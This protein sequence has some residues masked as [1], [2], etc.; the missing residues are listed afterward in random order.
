MTLNSDGT[1]S[2]IHDGSEN[3][4]DSFTYTVF[5]GV[6]TSNEATV[7]ITVSGVNDNIPVAVD[8]AITVAEGGTA[9]TL[10]GGSGTVLNNDTDADAPGD[11]L[12]V[13]LVDD[14]ANGTL[15]L[16]SDGTFTYI[17]DGS[18]NLSD[19]FTY[20]VFDGVNTSNEATVTITVSAVNDS[21]PIA[22]DDAITVA[23]GGTATTLVGGSGTVLNNDTDADQPGDTLTVSLVD[24]VANGTLTLNSDGTFSY[25]HDGSENLSDSFTYTVFDGVNTSN[26]ATVTITVSGI[27]DNSPVANPD[28]IVLD[29]G[30]TAT[31]L[32]GGANSVLAN[33]TDADQ[34]GDTLT[35]NDEDSGTAGIQ[36]LVGPSF[37]NL[38][39]NSDGTFSYTHDGSENFSDGFIYGATDG[40]TT[41]YASVTITINP[42]NDLVPNAADDSITV[43]EG[44]STSILDGGAT[45]VL[46]NDTDGDTP[47]NSLTVN[48]ESGAPGIQIVS[49]PANGVLVINP[50]GTFTYTHD[51]SETTSDS[52]VYRTFD[53]NNVSGDATVNITVNAT[54]DPPQLIT[55]NISLGESGEI[56]VDTNYLDGSDADNT[57]DQ[58]V[59]TLTQDVQ[60]GDLVLFGDVIEVGATWSQQ[61]VNDGNL[62]YRHNGSSILTDTFLVQL[63]DGN[64]S[65]NDNVNISRIVAPE[66]PDAPVSEEPVYR[67][68]I[69][70]NPTKVIAK[71]PLMAQYAT[72]LGTGLG[73][74][75]GFMN[76]QGINQLTSF[77]TNLGYRQLVNMG[78]TVSSFRMVD[79][80]PALSHTSQD[81]GFTS[82]ANPI[83]EVYSP[84]GIDSRNIDAQTFIQELSGTDRVQRYEGDVELSDEARIL[85]SDLISWM[86]RFQ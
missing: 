52:F 49:G 8:D 44:Q 2:Y 73:R 46:A 58:L 37:G 78:D 1:F 25:I 28:S 62:I 7:T 48:D 12:T 54:D 47:A 32:V 81:L 51:G 56:T 86:N 27:N 16:N 11:T 79:S 36:V 72:G 61:M 33:D 21:I 57:P 64:S 75:F 53:G 10:V 69:I 80:Q 66:T 35:V 19:S 60:N 17:H 38:T 31:T 3:L 4:S 40:N 41:T 6:N 68:P 42:V 83:Q 18:E 9:T 70:L 82:D 84:Y 30:G 71:S 15:T 50:D 24:D 65:V 23:E 20:T 22:V 34:P 43:D 59:Y 77:G 63:S 26:E 5:D 29:E 14:V 67:Q 45:S 39:I 74:S 13:N 55:R 85:I 76:L